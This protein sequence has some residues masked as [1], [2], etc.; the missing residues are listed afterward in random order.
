MPSMLRAS[1]GGRAPGTD[2]GVCV[3]GVVPV[4]VGAGLLVVG[5]GA[6]VVGALVGDRVDAVV[7][8]GVG[9]RVGVVVGLGVAVFV[10][11]SVGWG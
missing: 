7:G 1:H 5:V 10:V 9:T 3:A 8:D 11:S 4:D 6:L 2:Q